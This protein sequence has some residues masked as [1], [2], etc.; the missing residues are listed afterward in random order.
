M[1]GVGACMLDRGRETGFPS[2]GPSTAGRT[3]PFSEMPKL[4]PRIAGPRKKYLDVLGRLHAP[5]DCFA[6]RRH[7]PASSWGA[8]ESR[9]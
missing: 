6:M 2:I 7:P 9:V 8:E 5:V 3:G 1:E 4:P